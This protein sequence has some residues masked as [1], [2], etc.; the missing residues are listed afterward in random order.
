MRYNVK[1][2]GFEGQNIEVDSSFFSGVKLLVNGEPAPQGKK[3][4]EFVLQKN[5]GEQVTA[6]WKQQALG[7]DIPQLIIDGKTINL[8][9]PLKWYQWVWGGW[10]IGLVFAGGLIGAFFGVIAFALNA[11]VFRM[12]ISG[13]MKYVLTALISFTALVIYFVIAV[14]IQLAIGG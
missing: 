11:K 13:V 7:F 5:S 2:E 14:G 8:V 3:R 1:L 9:E 12:D 10:P 6:A 4:G